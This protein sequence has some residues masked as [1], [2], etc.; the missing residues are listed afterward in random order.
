VA[1]SS[2]C[3]GKWTCATSRMSAETCH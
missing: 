1:S 3:L 2:I